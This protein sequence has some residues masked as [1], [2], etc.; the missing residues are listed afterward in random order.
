[1]DIFDSLKWRF[2]GRG[3]DGEENGTVAQ[4][5]HRNMH[6][7]NITTLPYNI[8]NAPNSSSIGLA[9]INKK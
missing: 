2:D 1:M 5:H 4:L 8:A 7:L 9:L 6:D 3:E